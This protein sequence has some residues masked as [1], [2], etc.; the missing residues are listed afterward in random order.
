[1]DSEIAIVNPEDAL[2]FL[3]EFPANIQRRGEDYVRRGAVT[4]VRVVEPGTEFEVSVQGSEP[5]RVNLYC[6]GPEGWW[7]ECSCPYEEGFCKHTYAAMKTVLALSATGRPG[8]AAT[9]KKGK[10]AP[11]KSELLE[12]LLA[13]KGGKL[14]KPEKRFIGAVTRLYNDLRTR[15]GLPHGHDLAR[16]GLEPGNDYWNLLPLWQTYPRDDH[17]FWLYIVEYALE[18]NLILPAFMRPISDNSRIDGEL[19]EMRRQRELDRWFAFFKRAPLGNYS[20]DTAQTPIAEAELR[21]R[22]GRDCA[23]AEFRRPGAPEFTRCNQSQFDWINH[24]LDSGRIRFAANVELLWT[25]LLSLT[26]GAPLHRLNYGDPDAMSTLAGILDSPEIRSNIVDENGQAFSWSDSPLRWKLDEPEGARESY[27]LSLV[28]AEARPVDGVRM[29]VS[30]SR[31]Y[32]LVNECFHPGPPFDPNHM[33]PGTA[34]LL[35]PE[36]VEHREGIFFLHRIGARLPEKLARRIREVFLRPVITCR[37]RKTHAERC[38]VRVEAVDADGKCV[39][40]WGTSQWNP[41]RRRTVSAKDDNVTIIN[42][43]RLVQIPAVLEPLKLR[44]DWP[45]GHYTDVNKKFPDRICEWLKSVPDEVEV[46][47]E[48]ELASLRNATVAG[49]LRLEAKETEID[50]FDLSVVLDVADT[51]L[52]QDEIKL[53]LDAR[54]KWV[55]LDEKGW[56]RLAYEL[57]DDEDEQLARLG[58]NARELSSEPQRLHALQLAHPAAKNLLPAE[59]TEQLRLRADEIQTRIAPDI[60]ARIDATLRPYQVEGF[61]FLCYLSTNRF[62]G[63]L[64]DDMGLGKTLQALAWLLWLREQK[65]EAPPPALVVCPKSVMDN[66]SAEVARFAAGLRVKIWAPSE[67]STLPEHIADADLHV[68]NYNQLRMLGEPLGNVKFLAVILDEG[69]YIKN[70]SS[71]TAQCARAL[72]AEHR[73]VLTGTPIENRLLDLWSLMAF[74]MPGVLGSRHQFNKLYNGKDDPFA[75]LRLSSRVRPFL[76][77]RTKSQVARDLPDR[78]E[79]DLY[80]E[81]EGEQKK[82]YDAERKRAQQMLLKMKTQKQLN[83]LRFN[84]LTSLLRLRQICCHPA[85]VRDSSKARAAKMNA[86]VELLEPIIEEGNKVL[87]FSQFVELLELVEREMSARGWKHWMLTGKTEDRGSLVEAFQKHEGPGVFLISLKAGGAGLNLM[88][89]S[90]VVLFDPWWNPAVENQAIDRTHRIGQSRNVIAYRLLIKNSI[91]EKIRSLQK[92]KKAL[93]ENVLGEEQFSKNLTLEDFQYLL[94]D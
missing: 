85:L 60:P 63:I 12:R 72:K 27:Q 71:Q 32:Y 86:L 82:L 76:I 48:G 11:A 79:E 36:A 9:R 84:F 29:A 81:I 70:P 62:G 24:E 20:P 22:L 52:T 34:T 18:K 57:S 87:I 43:S 33:N 37:L 94:A 21:L 53:L 92:Q 39:E 13:A 46:R 25:R 69:Q 83:E 7:G 35:P 16:M 1:M 50:W 31:A 54:G 30:G 93:A 55:R 23:T 74:A 88:A 78:I 2:E 14:T 51:E 80:C 64:A 47:L 56:R 61:H 4:N 89:A 75:R 49:A 91:E 6:N 40:T 68:I 42:R 59:Q 41:A 44:N 77:R 26:G 45:D 5:Y 15:N 17:A 19:A 66:W 58:L 73:L 10:A 67:V 38:E 90:Y 65:G 28:D 8:T 3:Q